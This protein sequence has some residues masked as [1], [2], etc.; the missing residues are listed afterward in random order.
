MVFM[1]NS[2]KLV[3][4]WFMVIKWLMVC[5]DLCLDMARLEKSELLNLGQM[6]EQLGKR[7]LNFHI[8]Y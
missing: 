4:K 7:E 8:I 2:I 3:I 1:V 5:Q 6:V